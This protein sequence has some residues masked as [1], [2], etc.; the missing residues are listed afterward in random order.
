[1]E[2]REGRYTQ[3]GQRG[4][5]DVL[6]C[7]YRPMKYDGM[8]AIVYMKRSQVRKG[9]V[10]MQTECKDENDVFSLLEL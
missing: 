1:M 2:G 4:E 10:C 6:L 9:W 8:T 3:K 5:I 7:T